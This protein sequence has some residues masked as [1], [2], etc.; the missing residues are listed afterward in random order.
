MVSSRC[1]RGCPD[2]CQYWIASLMATSMLTEP[3]SQKTRS[4][5]APG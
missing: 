3:E 2:A 1:L 4:V 5:A